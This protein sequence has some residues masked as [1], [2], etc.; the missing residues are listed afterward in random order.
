MGTEIK[1]VKF[2][3]YDFSEF[4]KK[5]SKKYLDDLLNE[6]YKVSN[7][8]PK[9]YPVSTFCFSDFGILMYR[10]DLVKLVNSL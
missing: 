6:K 7:S 3:E 1:M 8:D 2:E 5:Y 10:D 9:E 4:S